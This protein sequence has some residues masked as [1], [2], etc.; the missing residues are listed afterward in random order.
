L[1]TSGPVVNGRPTA[2]ATN[3]LVSAAE[4]RNSNQ[5]PRAYDKQTENRKTK[6]AFGTVRTS[7]YKVGRAKNKQTNEF[8]MQKVE[9]AEKMLTSASGREMKMRFGNEK[10]SEGPK[11]EQGTAIN[12]L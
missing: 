2:F 6:F 8:G 12:H 9:S 5:W 1:S 4:E 10:A 11:N 3:A 7:E